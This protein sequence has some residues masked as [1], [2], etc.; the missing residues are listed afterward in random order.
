LRDT[1]QLDTATARAKQSGV[2]HRTQQ[3]ADKLVK[4]APAELV[5]EVIDGKKS[6]NKAI[7][8]ISPPKPVAAKPEPVQAVER[9]AEENRDDQLSGIIDQQQGAIKALAADN[10]V[11]L[12]VF[13]SDDKV[14]AS[15]AEVKKLTE[16][17]SDLNERINTLMDEKNE[18]VN[19]AEYW[20]D[21]FLKLEAEFKALQ[22]SV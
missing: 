13:E 22:K 7:K 2:G 6:L 12:K 20:K 21:R 8:E 11:M 5:K 1:A 10:E 17:N 19:S 15:I 9:E 18:A 3:L 4:E 14:L 16:L